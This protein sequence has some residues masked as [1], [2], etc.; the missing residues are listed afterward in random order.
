MKMIL[1]EYLASLK[2]RKELDALLPD[3]LSQMGLEVFSRPDVG[4]RQYGVDI[5]A[6]GGIDGEPESVYLLSV[7]SGDLGRNDWVGGSVQA[8]RPSL[9]EILDVYIP[10]HLPPKYRDKPI[11]ICLC[12]GG[13]IKETVRLNVSSYEDKN[14]TNLIT[15]SE[16]NGDVIASHIESHLLREELLPENCRPLLRK[17]LALLD[18][19][20]SSYKYFSL[21][22]R[23]LASSEAKKPEETLTLLRQMNLCLWIL[24][25][26]CRDQDNIECAYISSELTTLLAW[27]V[28]KPFFD[29]NKKTNLAIIDT[30]HAVDA[31]HNQITEDLLENKIFPHAGN[32]HA[33]SSAVFSSC[34]VDVNLKLF[35]I[36]GRVALS[37]LWAMSA[38]EEIPNIRT[39]EEKRSLITKKINIH[40]EVMV[41]M[42]NNNPILSSP[43]KDDHAI[44][45]GLA[46]TFLALTKKSQNSI[47]A[48]LMNI[49]Q[50]S[51]KL[52]E[53]KGSYPCN[54][55]A[56]HDL[57]EHPKK[58]VQGYLEEVTAGS[59]LYPLIAL[60]AAIYNFNDLYRLVQKA[61]LEFLAHCNFQVWYPDSS[62]EQNFY[63]NSN[64]HG[65]VLSGVNVADTKE[66]FIESIFRECDATQYFSDLSGT[67][68]NV[69][70]FPLILM[71]C[72]HYRL[73][74]PMHIF[75]NLPNQQEN[76]KKRKQ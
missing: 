62:T 31:L 58:E 11:V 50:S 26:W 18:E 48:W 23:S 52:L 72:R 76:L 36:L 16:W 22:V 34:P 44:D 14:R 54:L 8:L 63:T 24:Y 65:A 46:I 39:L 27:E 32:L 43:Y 45:I 56:Y 35:D 51:L 7:K 73:P 71:A 19:P 38:L 10:T 42:I 55:N 4:G 40:H 75:R 66:A 3:L 30:L 74:I 13:D 21:L 70:P 17:S 49:M 9:D 41:Q 69:F 60:V 67:T 68:F 53:E 12:F 29:V 57:I 5:A 33:L 61:K 15:F 28:S 2:E 25:V 37:G 20:E 59:I 6:F 47:H 1:R 64:Q